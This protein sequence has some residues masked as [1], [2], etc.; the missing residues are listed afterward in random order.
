MLRL[1]VCKALLTALLLL[2]FAPAT[3]WAVQFQRLPVIGDGADNISAVRGTTQDKRGFIWFGGENGLARYDGQDTVVYQTDPEDPRSLSGNY[4]WSLTTDNDGVV[5]IGTWRGLNRYNAATNDFDHFVFDPD[6][7]NSI[8]SSSVLALAVDQQN[9][10][11]IG[12][13]NGLNIFDPER[14]HFQHFYYSPSGRQGHNFVQEVFVDSQNRIWAGTNKDGLLLLDRTTGQFTRF[15]HKPGDPASIIDNDIYAIEEDHLGRLWVGTQNRGLSR[16]NPDGKT[17]THYQHDPS[18]PR[19]LANNQ[20][21][22]IL[23][24]QHKNL[25]IALDRGGLALYVPES[26]S[27]RIFRHSAYDPTT[28]S[29]NHP[30]NLYEDNQGDLWLG[31]FPSG[32]SFLDQSTSV[33]TNYS[34]K[35]DDPKSISDSGILCFFEDSDGTLWIGTENGLNAF[36]RKDDTFQHY[37][38]K[39]DEQRGL[40]FGAV[41]TVQEDVTGDLWVG[42]WSGGLYRFNKTTGAF[43]NYYPDPANPASL[44][45]EYVWKVIRDDQDRIWVATGTGGLNRY[46]RETDSFTHFTAD[47]DDEGS[48]VS[49]R[50]WTAMKD[51]Q[52]YLWLG[53]LGGLDRFDPRTQEFVHYLHDPEDEGSISSNHVVSLFEDSRGTI[54]AGTRDGGLNRFDRESGQFRSLSVRDGLPSASISSIIEDDA[55]NIWVTAVSGIARIDPNTLEVRSY[56]KSHGLV[57]TNFSRDATFKD[58]QGRLYV[59]GIEGFSVFHPADLSAKMA[60]PPVAITDFRIL[61]EPVPIGGEQDV[62]L[63]SITETEALTLSHAHSM[64]SFHFAA[65][66][67]RSPEDNQYAYMLEGFDKT[68]HTV[69]NQRSATYT[70]IAPGNYIFRVKAANRDGVWNEEGAAVAIEITPPLWRTGWAYF[71]YALLLG[72][73]LYI[74]NAYKTLRVTSDVYKALSATDPLTGISNR[75][76]ITRITNELFAGHEVREG[77]G[78]LVLDIDHFKN[79]ND[80]RGHDSGDRILK[81]FTDLV[82]R[83]IRADDKFARWGGEEFLLLSSN[84]HRDGLVALAEKLRRLVEDHVFEQTHAPL[85]LTVSIGVAYAEPGDDFDGLFKRADTALYEAKASG[86]NRV[87]PAA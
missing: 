35:P 23:E 66:S 75:A 58:D 16:M 85:R 40:Q 72:G 74:G 2:G 50:V 11:I 64:F 82:S 43:H 3:A 14:A 68:W 20:V 56:T 51:S 44:N 70:S 21:A 34:H 45:S 59:G 36:N 27:F 22:G 19:S 52:G 26:D 5:W 28:I 33:F 29:S 15:S 83:G 76:G 61:N 81:E 54:W 53:T 67:Y 13:E 57:S 87:A 1:K 9:N 6:A 84:I 78:L 18:K 79:I 4:I 41:L 86:R 7:E 46:D 8:S 63:R 10:L 48:I 32:A 71:G 17:F 69:G 65:L 77:V 39:P 62:L 73:I 24:D 80:V 37:F 12:T 55:G 47:A 38:A 60:P 30:R 31:M 49:N 25:W 42:T